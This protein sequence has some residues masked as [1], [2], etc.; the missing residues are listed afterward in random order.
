MMHM[1]R[2]I[3]RE[4]LLKALKKAE[5]PSAPNS[6]IQFIITPVEERG[7]S[8]NSKDDW[9]RLWALSE[10]NTKGRCFELE[11][12]VK[13]FSGLEPLYP[14]WIKVILKEERE[15]LTIVELQTSLRFRSPSL[16]MNQNTNHPPFIVVPVQL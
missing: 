8:L 2:E 14:L 7:K 4:N 13:L 16:L 12:V 1:S 6:K 9:M 15:D 11:D 3:F 10:R 5:I